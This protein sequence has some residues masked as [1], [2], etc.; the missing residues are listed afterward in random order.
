MRTP[1]YT[2]Y[3]KV[4]EEA[5]PVFQARNDGV[6]ARAFRILLKDSRQDEHRLYQVGEFDSEKVMLFTMDAKEILVT[7]EVTE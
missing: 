7:K 3:D 4:A 2:I 6:A 5:G 1:V